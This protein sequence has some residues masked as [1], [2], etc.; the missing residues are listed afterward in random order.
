M[1]TF[2]VLLHVRLDGWLVGWSLFSRAFP[3]NDQSKLVP[4][5]LPRCCAFVSLHRTIDSN[6]NITK[7]ATPTETPSKYIYEYRLSFENC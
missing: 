5:H 4:I 2:P 7:A 3:S 1:I 6:N